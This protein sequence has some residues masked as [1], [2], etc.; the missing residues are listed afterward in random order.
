M[1]VLVLGPMVAARDGREVELGGRRQRMVLAALLVARG[2]VLPASRLQELVWADSDHTAS[3]AT[4]HGYVAGLRR[5]LEPERESRSAGGVLV[6]EGPGYAVRVPPDQIDAERFTAM[7]NRGGALLDQGDPSEALSTL[8]SALALWRGPAYADVDGAPFVLPEVARL[9][10]LRASAVE[11]RLAALLELGRHE[12]TIGE[13][14]ALVIEQPIRERGWEML[15]TALYRSGRQGDALAAIRRARSELVEQLGLE[16][17]PGLQGL[18]AAILDQSLPPAPAPTESPLAGLHLDAPT[19]VSSNVS[20]LAC[21]FVG[22]EP[23][24]AAA[25]AAVADHRLVTF[26]GP[27]GIGKTRLALELARHRADP[28]GPW[29]VELASLPDPGLVASAIAGALGIPV[30]TIDQLVAALADRECLLVVDN[31]E[32]VLAGVVPVVAALLSRCPRLRILVTSREALDLPAE[33]LVVV[34]PLPLPDA[35]T[36]LVHRVEAV[37]KLAPVD[38]ALAARVCAD[39][40]GLPLAIEL[41]AGQCRAL[42]L[43]EV[44]HRLVDRFALLTAGPH[45]PERHRTLANAIGWSYQA[46]TDE[47][48]RMLQRLT[49]FA[50]GFDL[51]A[52][53]VVGGEWPTTLTGLVRKSLVTVDATRTPRRFDLLMS[54]KEYASQQAPL[55]VLTAARA[56]HRE[57]LAGLTE[58]ALLRL[59]SSGGGR[60]MQRLATERSNIRAALAS[61]DKDGDAAAAVRICGALSWF[62]FRTGLIDEGLRESTRALAAS[63]GLSTPDVQVARARTVGGVGALHHLA[64]QGTLAV[65]ALREAMHLARQVGSIPE[66]ITETAYLALFEGFGGDLDEAVPLADAA[67]ALARDFGVPSLLA[68][69]LMVRGQL[70]RLAGNLT[71]SRA[72]LADAYQLAVDC[73]HSWAAISAGWADAKTSL[74]LGE[75]TAAVDRLRSVILRHSGND[76]TGMVT[77]VH[78]LAGALAR[79]GRAEVGARLLGAASAL[80]SRIG[81]DPERM[82]PVDG[83]ASAAAV[84]SALTPEAFARAEAEGRALSLRQVLELVAAA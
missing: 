25:A 1:E 38:A 64:G 33:H 49:V 63:A 37:G 69:A 66:V 18:E 82:D 3:K 67:L 54:I 51:E 74:D 10:T 39:L 72:I 8:D 12:A 23:D 41:A 28:D 62:W 6:R 75:P 44:A 56:A 2:R 70:H 42:S 60:W 50:S 53:R 29:V 45:R 68:E 32:H 46:L 65:E 11:L 58:T 76:L 61:A 57:W 83:A 13:L 36:L 16:T 47:E 71:A 14:E 43:P 48:R 84:A 35:V 40:D 79:C 4:L 78:T 27:A 22:R 59:G 26:T 17:G 80:R 77:C 34:P 5:A 9:D 19:F 24:L 7:V 15:A 52:A 20:V 21:S 73:G 81:F 30:S 31:A 55:E